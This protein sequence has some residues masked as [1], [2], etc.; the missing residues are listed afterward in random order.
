V[1]VHSLV[2]DEAS[3]IVGRLGSARYGIWAEVGALPGYDVTPAEL[4]STAAVLSQIGEEARSELSRLGA[5]A[6]T[7]LDGG[8]WGPAA[9]AFGRGWTQWHAGAV[10][11]LDAL[12]AM[13]RL[14]A[15]TGA[16][17]GAAEDASVGVLSQAAG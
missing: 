5:D 11:V 8:W 6:A 15:A 1:V 9:T 3:R 4:Q 2:D 17:Y 13:A 10:E 12:E 16:D 7:L 14:L